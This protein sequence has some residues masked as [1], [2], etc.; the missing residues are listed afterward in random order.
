M[1]PKQ[2]FHDRARTADAIRTAGTIIFDMDGVIFDTERFYIDCCIPAAQRLDMPGIEETCLQCIGLT[3]QETEKRLLARYEDPDLLKRFHLETSRIF[4]RR[5][6]REGG[7]P[8]KPGARELL[9]WLSERGFTVGLASS[10]RHEIILRELRDAGLDRF[11]Q[12]IIG[13]D[14]ANRS[15]PA[16][17]IFLLTADRLAARPRECVVIEDSHNGI[18][19]ANAAGM[20]PVMVPDL[21]PPD[22]E[23]RSLAF[24]VFD[25]LHDVRAWLERAADRKR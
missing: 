16:P 17:D 23:I 25:S 13:G 7:L 6:D 20:I 1:K 10:T 14:M 8:V 3:E 11:F 24:Q 12:E 19:A 15:K 22:E 18:R 21:L 9:D 4:R 5:Y 2:E